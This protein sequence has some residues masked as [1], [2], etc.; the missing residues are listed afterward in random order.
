MSYIPMKETVYALKEYYAN[1]ENAEKIIIDC[2]V[3]AAGADAIGG[4]IPGLAIPATIVSCF[5]AVW[6]MYGMICDELGISL[7]KNV[8]KLLAKAVLA[9][10]AANLG[11]AL[12]AMIAGMLIPGG[13][14]LA[15]A[16]VAFVAVYLGGFVFLKLVLNMARKSNDL[17]SFSDI[18]IQEMKKTVK[19]TKVGKEDLEAAKSVFQ[20]NKD[21]IQ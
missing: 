21:S 20:N 2:A 18:S 4:V 16:V 19:D 8:L 12:A 7:K 10:V 6:A 1:A 17:K 9:N 15:S 5:G 11:G 3:V 14:I 13:S